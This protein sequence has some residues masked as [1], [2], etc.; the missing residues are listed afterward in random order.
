MFLPWQIPHVSAEIAAQY[1]IQQNAFI[2]AP[3]LVRVRSRGGLRMKTAGPD[4]PLEIQPNFLSEPADV[5]ALVAGG[6]IG[7]DLASQ[8]A[9]GDLIKHWVAPAKRM[10]RKETVAFL[11][12]SCLRYNHPVGTCAMGS[13]REAVVD[14]ELRVRGASGLRIAEASVMPTIPSANTQAAVVMI[15]EF[16]SRLHSGCLSG[17]LKCRSSAVKRLEPA[18]SATTS[19]SCSPAGFAAKGGF[20]AGAGAVPA[21]AHN[22][23]RSSFRAGT[24]GRKRT[25]W[26]QVL[27]AQA[28]EEV[29]FP[30]PSDGGRARGGKRTAPP[31]PPG[32]ALTRPGDCL[33]AKLRLPLLSNCKPSLDN[34]FTVFPLAPAW[35]RWTSSQS[36]AGLSAQ[37]LSRTMLL[38]LAAVRRSGQISLLISSAR[39]LP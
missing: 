3:A 25:S 22:T 18:G 32:R 6:E 9:L 26:P 8:P 17:S 16:A 36:F 34:L 11:R 38:Q 27:A 13:A 28:V 31:R 29:R 10:S 7:P 23:R 12:R 30:N 4:S 2:L 19:N 35:S 33:S 20:G 14:A 5:E 39:T 15:A 24:N 21:T 37:V 1:A